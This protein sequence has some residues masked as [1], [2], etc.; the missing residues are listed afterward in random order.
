[1]CNGVAIWV[2]WHLDDD[3]IIS[4]GPTEEIIP[5]AR[6]AWDPYTRQ[7]VHL[8]QDITEVTNK[9]VFLSSFKF[10]PKEGDMQFYFELIKK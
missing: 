10:D 1:M 3:I 6:I 4:S 5:G 9:N 8:L 2:D 7:G